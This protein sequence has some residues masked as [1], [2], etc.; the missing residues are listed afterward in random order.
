MRTQ[1][2]A[3][4]NLLRVQDGANGININLSGVAN[5]EYST[6]MMTLNLTGASGLTQWRPYFCDFQGSTSGYVIAS[7]EL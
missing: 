7:A 2:S 4:A 6:K 3:T 5:G 1:P